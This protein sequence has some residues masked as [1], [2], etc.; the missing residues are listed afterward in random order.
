MRVYRGIVCLFCE[1]FCLFLCFNEMT[2]NFDSIYLWFCAYPQ[3]IFS[4]NQFHYRQPTKFVGNPF[5]ETLEGAASQWWS[6]SPSCGE[7]RH[8]KI[9]FVGVWSSRRRLRHGRQICQQS[10]C[11][12][13]LHKGHICGS[14][15]RQLE[16]STTSLCE[17]LFASTQTSK[18][19]RRQR[20]RFLLQS[21]S[22]GSTPQIMTRWRIRKTVG[23]H[24]R[25]R[26]FEQGSCL[27]YDATE[28]EPRKLGRFLRWSEA[29]LNWPW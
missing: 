4:K 1:I 10:V 17:E 14:R 25:E 18:R 2:T 22:V 24:I 3:N 26:T 6:L 19:W 15:R 11:V 5:H 12:Q 13:S 21:F 8:G 20:W 16:T 9:A 7:R 29:Q 23:Y 27:E 28:L